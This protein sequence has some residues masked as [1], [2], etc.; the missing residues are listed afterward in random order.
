MS[1]LLPSQ[2]K[3]LRQKQ[4][5]AEARAKKVCSTYAFVIEFALGTVLWC[6]EI[7]QEAEEKNEE[8]ST[9]GVS[10]TGKRQH[11]KPVDLDPHGEKLLQVDFEF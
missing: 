9:A 10:K 1:R 2:K 5:K 8:T 7:F 11:T 3:K 6:H 4:R